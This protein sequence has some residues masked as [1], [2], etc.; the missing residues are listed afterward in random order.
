MA[1]F[2][3][4]VTYYLNFYMSRFGN[5]FFDKN[6][7]ITKEQAFACPAVALGDS[8]RDHAKDLAVGGG[9]DKPVKGDDDYQYG[10]NGQRK[11]LSSY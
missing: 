7:I 11:S 6:R 3:G 9:F 2:T 5:K 4:R 10:P 8:L 1:G